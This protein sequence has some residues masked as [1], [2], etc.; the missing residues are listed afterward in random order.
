MHLEGPFLSREMSGALN[1]GC[2]IR[3]TKRH[4]DVLCAFAP[5]LSCITAAP[6]EEGGSRWQSA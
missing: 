5:L 3:P 4:M 1:R 2:I 6:E